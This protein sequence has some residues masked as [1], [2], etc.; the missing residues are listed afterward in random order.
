MPSF[1]LRSHKYFFLFTAVC[2]FFI[3]RALKASVPEPDKSLDEA[4]SI[5][6]NAR[7]FQSEGQSL[8]ALQKFEEAHVLF[9]A[10]LR[11]ETN[12]GRISVCHRRLLQIDRDVD[13][14]ELELRR[15]PST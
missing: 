13:R 10:L 11:I 15:A 1:R 6:Y 8:K 5:F 4:V 3:S 9:E 7:A 2:V 14:I 12:P